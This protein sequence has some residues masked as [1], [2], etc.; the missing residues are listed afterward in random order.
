MSVD[1][2]ELS[3]RSTN[4]LKAAKIEKIGEL[5]QK[6]EAEM[7]KYRN[8]GK[9]SLSEISKILAEMGL[10]FGLK[11]DEELKDVIKPNKK[12]GK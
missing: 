8:F 1:E 5:V 9:K 6:S 11:L 10:S 2:L 7:L 3:V 12:E 4:C